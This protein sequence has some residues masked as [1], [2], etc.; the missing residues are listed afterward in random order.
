MSTCGIPIIRLLTAPFMVQDATRALGNGVTSE[1]KVEHLCGLD[2]EIGKDWLSELLPIMKSFHIH[3]TKVAIGVSKRSQQSR[4]TSLSLGILTSGDYSVLTLT[5]S[6]TTRNFSR[7][8]TRNVIW[9]SCTRDSSS[10]ACRA[11]N[12]GIS[13]TNGIN[14]QDYQG[15]CRC[16]LLAR[17][18]QGRNFLMPL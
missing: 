17:N 3:S 6:K 11:G 13:A 10:W 2:T 12:G 14:L 4:Q 1:L 18:I 7:N 16:S 8:F 15:T 5:S 9:N